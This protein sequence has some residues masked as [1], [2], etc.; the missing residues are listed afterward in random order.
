MPISTA[1]LSRGFLKDKN[2]VV[3]AKEGRVLM[4]KQLVYPVEDSK[5]PLESTEDDSCT[6]ALARIEAA[7]EETVENGEPKD[8]LPLPTPVVSTYVLPKFDKVPSLGCKLVDTL[9]QASWQPVRACPGWFARLRSIRKN[10]PRDIAEQSHVFELKCPSLTPVDTVSVVPNLRYLARR[11]YERLKPAQRQSFDTLSHEYI[12]RQWWI[13]RSEAELKAL[14]KQYRLL[15]PA[16][17]FLVP[18]K[19]HRSDR[20]VVDLRRANSRIPRATSSPL[21]VATCVCTSRLYGS[22]F[23]CV[24]DISR[25]FYRLRLYAILAVLLVGSRLFTSDRC[26]FGISSGPGNL[27][28]SFGWLL[29]SLRDLCRSEDLTA[30]LSEFMDDLQCSGPDGSWLVCVL[31]WVLAGCGFPAERKK[32]QAMATSEAQLSAGNALKK[33]G[34]PGDFYEWQD[35]VTILGTLQKYTADGK[36]LVVSC[37]RSSRLTVAADQ[38]NALIDGLTGGGDPFIL[39]KS[40]AFSLGGNLSYDC[41]GC[42]PVDRVLADALRSVIARHYAE[43]DMHLVHGVSTRESIEKS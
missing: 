25:A 20:L 27:G 9:V 36:Y 1:S 19:L 38:A 5:A 41:C 29:S 32:F 40:G 43:S 2:I 31:L 39:S 14:T 15:D 3:L 30:L 21:T 37:L 23:C 13:E 28:G 4:E 17:V 11:A 24:L 33:M 34:L 42:H 18:G 22:S 10:E 35:S 8:L 12:S 7:D 6:I 26:T 16:V